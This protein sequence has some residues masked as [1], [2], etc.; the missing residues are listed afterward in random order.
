MPR[1]ASASVTVSLRAKDGA[2]GKP[3]AD[4]APARY[5]YLRGTAHSS[6]HFDGVTT[7]T[8]PALIKTSGGEPDLSISS[9]GLT[10]V[11]LDRQTLRVASRQTFDTLHSTDGV[12]Q[13]TQMVQF[14][15]GVDD[16]VLL[17]VV[18]WDA[19]YLDDVVCD[20]SLPEVVEPRVVDLYVRNGVQLAR[21]ES[22]SAGG[23][24]ADD[25]AAACRER[26]LPPRSLPTD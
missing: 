25:V 10:V 21:F 3:G 19:Y 14:L 2:D 4:G 8:T 18:S 24:V 7:A 22:N 15:D 9:R 16:S 11:T 23:R 6:Q 12:E 20:N 1:L 5:V 17:A 26:G 13:G